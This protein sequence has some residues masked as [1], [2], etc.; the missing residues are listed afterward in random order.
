MRK[1]KVYNIEYCVE[2]EDVCELVDEDEDCEKKIEEIKANLPKSII[3]E[4]DENDFEDAEER[5]DY[6]VD[7]ATERTGWLIEGCSI[8]AVK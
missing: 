2:D 6:L 3:I 5:N 7:E 4:I 1:Y 8:K